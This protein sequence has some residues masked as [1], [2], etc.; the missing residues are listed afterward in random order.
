M[1]FSIDDKHLI[2][3]P[4]EENQYTVREFLR[5]F[6]NKKW[7]CGGLNH[8]LEKMDKYGSVERLAS[9]GRPWSTHYTESNKPVCAQSRRPHTQPLLCS[10]R[11]HVKHTFLARLYITSSRKTCRLD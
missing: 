9:S 7:S 8:L 11:Q 5:E 1:P 2:K 3:V 10:V 6:P 4:R